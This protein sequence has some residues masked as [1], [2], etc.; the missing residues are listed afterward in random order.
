M[1]C[2][3]FSKIVKSLYTMLP[4]VSMF[5]FVYVL[6]RLQCPEKTP[7]VHSGHSLFHLLKHL[8]KMVDRHHLLWPNHYLKWK[9][10]SSTSHP[11]GH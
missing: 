4:T 6:I 3:N 8:T 2:T 1:L 7:M 9:S 10:R 11:K 5:V